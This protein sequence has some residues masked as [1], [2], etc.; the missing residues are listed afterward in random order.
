MPKATDEAPVRLRRRCRRT[1]RKAIDRSVS[2][3]SN[4]RGARGRRIDIAN[5]YESGADS[6]IAAAARDSLLRLHN[7]KFRVSTFDYGTAFARNIGWVTRAEQDKLRGARVAV[8]GLGGVGGFHLL[9]LARLGVGKFTVAEFD[10][11]DLANFNRQIG[12]TMSSIGR[13][14]LDVLVEM[15][16]DINPELDIRTFPAGVQEDNVDE[17]LCDADLYVDGLDFFAFQ[18]RRITFAACARMGVPA[19]TAAPLGMGVAVLNFL[20]GKMSFEEYFRLDG[21]PESEQALRFLLGL[22]P[23]MLQRAYVA[24]PSQVNLEER[25]GPS[26]V[27]ACQLC[28]GV[29]ATEALKIL[30]G[31]GKIIAAPRGLH[32]DAYR[33]KYTTT[34]RPGGNH[35]PVQ[36]IALAIARRQL[37]RM[38]VYASQSTAAPPAR[39]IEAIL[40]LARWA[41]SGD[42]TQP[43]RFQIVADDHVVVHGFDTRDHCVYDL[44]GHASQLSIGAMLETLRI[45]ATGY[46][47][48]A[49]ISRRRETPDSH[50]LFDV[51][52]TPASDV[53]PS[54]LIPFI[55]T[56]TTQRRPFRSR[57]L[58]PREKEAIERS[59]GEHFEIC[60][61]EG[62]A[63]KLAMARLLFASAKLRLTLRE[64]F[65]VHRSVIEWNA[66]FS[67]EKI[68]DRAVGLDPV[69]TRLMR[70]AFQDWRRVEFLNTYLA[71]TVPPRIQLD[72]VP[73]L[74]C[75]AHVLIL[76]R[77]PLN[78]LD[79]FV[80]AGSAVQR[81]WLTVTR[82]G[83]L[84]QPEITP[85]I[86][87]GYAAEGKQ[88]SAAAGS[89][90]VA[91]RLAERLSALVGADVWRRCVWLGRVGAGRPGQARSLRLPL[92][93]LRYVSGATSAEASQ[94]HDKV[95][96]QFTVTDQ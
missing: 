86:F 10:T 61:M 72:L 3:A 32:F 84:H 73:A 1:L 92:T 91:G 78:G 76:A 83:L 4:H 55:R 38:H 80:E 9:T 77:R 93:K 62:F 12:A 54:E 31:R 43:W 49:M 60:W 88:F 63:R 42:N 17:F 90:E 87:A 75:G 96:T 13:P 39:T 57:A 23:A 47:L 67:A 11:F 82:L 5:H 89:S 6:I 85:L 70:W 28:A 29:A 41:P 58:D 34:W 35:N 14:K 81:L 59:V 69:T 36:R 95:S 20:P 68:P 19:V 26:T 22:S 2:S 25:R 27:M 30:L 18:A 33:N 52:L 37:A 64:A 71:G 44:D 53:L 15:A 50:P 45:A 46:G 24:D 40:D 56:R 21:L 16:R 66:T 94:V 48:R 74:A 7:F 79:D 8:A 51:K 65:E